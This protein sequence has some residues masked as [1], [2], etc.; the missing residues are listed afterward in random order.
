MRIERVAWL[1]GLLVA[2]TALPGCAV[3]SGA[4][5]VVRAGSAVRGAASAGRT[6]ALRAAIDAIPAVG[7]M[8]FTVAG[9]QTGLPVYLTGSAALA[10]NRLAELRYIQGRHE[11]HALID[12]DV[13]YLALNDRYRPTSDKTPEH[14]TRVT[15]D[16]QSGP[17]AIAVTRIDEDLADLTPRVQLGRLVTL[18]SVTAETEDQLGGGSAI[19][20]SVTAPMES[21]QAIR[22]PSLRQ[23]A[24]KL[25][26]DAGVTTVIAEAWVGPGHRLLRTRLRGGGIDD[27]SINYKFLP[28]ALTIPTPAGATAPA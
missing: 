28:A 13:H 25:Y 10:G 3:V 23:L 19:H 22:K 27:V 1:A 26:E 15:P 11:L 21:Y 5:A 9:V 14:W 17:E 18:G 4:T 16:E 6:A 24:A 8:S 2:A 7:T 12:G 20:Y